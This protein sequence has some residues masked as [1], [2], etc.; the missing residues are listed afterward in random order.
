M[1]II[2]IIIIIKLQESEVWRERPGAGSGD[3][4]GAFD[5]VYSERNACA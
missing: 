3:F 4:I 2:N 1:I 5:Y